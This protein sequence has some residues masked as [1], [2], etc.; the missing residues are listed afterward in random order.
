MDLDYI[1][2]MSNNQDY[3]LNQCI[4]IISFNFFFKYSVHVLYG[5]AYPRIKITVW[6]PWWIFAI[7]PPCTD[8]TGPC[9]VPSSTHLSNSPSTDSAT[10]AVIQGYLSW[11][12]RGGGWRIWAFHTVHLGWMVITAGRAP[13][14][15]D[16]SG[17]V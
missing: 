11:N 17:K 15:D 13:S 4:N 9:I 3:N 10:Q 1:F 14:A 16:R 2:N 5:C 12:T 6:N 7:E 8:C